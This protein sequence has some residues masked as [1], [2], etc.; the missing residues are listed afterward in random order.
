MYQTMVLNAT[1]IL[2]F[3]KKIISFTFLNPNLNAIHIAY[4]VA[5]LLL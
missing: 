3:D 2:N 5:F 4:M 1:Q